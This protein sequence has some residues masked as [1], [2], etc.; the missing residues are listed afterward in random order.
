LR[1]LIT[2]LA[3]SPAEPGCAGAQEKLG[4]RKEKKKKK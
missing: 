3:L 2:L 4:E 1:I